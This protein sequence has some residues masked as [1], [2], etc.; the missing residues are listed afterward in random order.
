MPQVSFIVVNWNG[1]SYIKDCLDSLLNQ[2]FTDFEII[3]ADNCSTDNSVVFVKHHYPDLVFVELDRNYGFAGGNNRGYQ[4]AAGEYIALVNNDAVLCREWLQHMIGTLLDDDRIGCCAS[5]IIIAGTD[6]IDSVGDIFTT[7]FSGTKQGEFESAQDFNT[8][9]E[10]HGACA[11]AAIYRKSMLDQIGF[12]DEDFFLN[13]EDTDLNMRI[14][15]AGWKCRYVPKAIAYHQVNRTIGTMSYTSVYH[16][17]RNTLWVWIK[18]T[19]L[20]FL[21]THFPQRIVYEVSGFVLFCLIHGKWSPYL[22]GKYDA[23][24]G[25]PRMIRKRSSVQKKLAPEKIRQDL[26]PI[27]RYIAQKT[28]ALL[29]R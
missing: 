27:T 28:A 7:A 4:Y 8:P 1:E 25:L 13:H 26:L 22:K 19:P 3:F 10:V 2:S 6:T 5:K 9:K 20:R 16:F 23:V 17:S 29:Q 12:F 14:W 11:A 18:N 15:L 24:K 21:L